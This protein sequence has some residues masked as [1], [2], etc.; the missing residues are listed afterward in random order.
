MRGIFLSRYRTQRRALFSLSLAFAPA[1]LAQPPQISGRSILNAASYMQPGLPAGSI[2]RGSLFSLF[3]ARMGPAASPALAFPL[4]PNLGG[5]TIQVVQGS[6]I[7]QAIPVFVSPTQL[8]AIMP[9]NAPL[10]AVSIYAFFN[11]AKSPPSPARIVTDSFGIFTINGGG[12]GPGVLQNFVDATHLPVNLPSVAAQPGQTMILYGTGLGAGLN[13]DNVAPQAGSLPT[14]VEVFVG[15]Q[16]A[17]TTYT[18]R[19]PCCSGLDQIVFTVPSNAPPGCWVPVQI[20]TSGTTVSNT[21]TM[22]ISSNGSSCSDPLNPLTAPFLAGKR[23]GL[24]GLL[25]TDITEDVGLAK[26]GT[27]TTEA[28]MTTFQQENPIPAAPFSAVLSLPPAGTC[29]A[30]TAAGDLLDGDAVPGADDPGV[31]FLDAGTALTLSSSTDQRT[32]RRPTNKARNYQPLGYTYTGS[33]RKPSLFLNAGSLTLAGPG[34]ADV[35]SFTAPITLPNPAALTWTNRATTLIVTRSQ[36]LTVNWTGAPP[37]QPVVIFGGATDAP[38]NSSAVFA[39]LAPAG[40]ASFTVPAL[41]LANFPATRTNLLNSKGAIYVGAL[42]TS[43]PVSFSASGI[44]NGA[45]LPATFF[46]KTVIFQ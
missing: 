32:I 39:C 12:V 33:R 24:V 1:L 40:S 22:A 28:S 18:G 20:R 3:G 45:I 25:R 8:N 42:P 4:L 34:G 21:T 30:Y 6:T 41:A 43:N 35:G 38:T 15:G 31:K 13:P 7:V 37:D 46:G 14:K 5:V 23:I 36:G 27:V 29:T 11:N 44:D 26:T 16:V 17:T 10:G 9:S 19:S 2:A